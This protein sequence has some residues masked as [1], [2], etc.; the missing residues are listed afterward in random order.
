MISVVIPTF[1][2]E[3]YLEQCLD[4][5][6]GQS[7]SADQTEI[8][9][10][11]NGSTDGIVDIAKKY[12][13]NIIID[14]DANVSGLRNIGA[15]QSKGDILFFLDSDCV[16]END[17]IE[18]ALRIFDTQNVAVAGCW[19]QISSNPTWVEKVWDAHMSWRREADQDVS[20]V[21]SGDLI[22]KKSVFDNVDGFNSELQTGEDTDICNRLT[23]SGNR[24]FAS[25]DVAVVHLGEAKTIGEFYLKQKWH[26]A[27]AIQR[28]VREFPR[29]IADKTFVYSLVLLIAFLG[30]IKSAL[31]KNIRDMLCFILLALLIPAVMSVKTIARTNKYKYLFTLLFL[32]F[33][34]GIARTT[35]FLN[36]NLWLNEIIRRKK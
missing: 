25:S 7:F 29:F 15:K 16:P 28:F 4:A 14:K 18:N 22:I 8:I 31:G 11:D 6:K 12:T 5:V 17:W 21:P 20:W 13:D 32:Y 35:A 10:V 34:Y 30:M 23:N 2:S 27:G 1:N 36:L 9:I 33:V 3:K 19:Y 26:G 24:I